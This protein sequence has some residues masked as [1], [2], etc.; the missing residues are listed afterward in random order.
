MMNKIICGGKP[1]IDA[2]KKIPGEGLNR[3]WPP[4][5]K[6]DAVVK[7]NSRNFLAIAE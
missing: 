7:A 3:A 1:G 5:L 2:T 6:M 4:L